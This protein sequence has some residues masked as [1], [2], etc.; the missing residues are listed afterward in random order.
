MMMRKIMKWIRWNEQATRPHRWLR[1]DPRKAPSCR[2]GTAMRS[3]AGYLMGG[4]GDWIA[5]ECPNDRP[6][7]FF[8]HSPWTTV[9]LEI[10]P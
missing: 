2:C 3:R 9:Q 10:K 8:R 5:Y 7:N 4:P 1:G 6:W